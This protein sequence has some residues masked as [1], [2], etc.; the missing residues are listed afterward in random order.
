M[1]AAIQH[2][3]QGGKTL[4]VGK[5]YE[6]RNQRKGTFSMR[7][8]SIDGEWITGEVVDGVAKAIM[9]YNVKEEGESVTVRSCHSYFIE[10]E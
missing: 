2:V 5:T 8:A 6:V 7:V 10:K 4:E 9:S 1:K 3:V